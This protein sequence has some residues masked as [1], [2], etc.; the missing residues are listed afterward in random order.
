MKSFLLINS[1]HG[2]ID[3]DKA[4]ALL[5]FPT[6]GLLLLEC[7]ELPL[8]YAICGASTIA[9]L[10][11]LFRCTELTWVRVGFSGTGP[12]LISGV[13]TL[14]HDAEIVASLW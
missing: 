8:S 10:L 5:I 13:S 9:E 3:G 14:A 4:T 12:S 11:G 7:V 6:G 1:F 2:Q